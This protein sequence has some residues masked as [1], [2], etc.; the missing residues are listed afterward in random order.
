[1]G[2]LVALAIAQSLHEPGGG[3]AQV[4]GD[5][6]GKGVL[7]VRN[8]RGVGLVQ[9][10]GFGSGG[11]VDRSL[12][13]GQGPLR[14]TD[15]VEGFLGLHGHGQGVRVRHAHVFG[16]KADQSPG[17]VK[18]VLSGLQ[19][20]GQPVDRSVRV[21]V[22]K[23]FV[24]RRDEIVVFLA[25]LV[26]EKHT[27]LHRVSDQ[28]L[29]DPFPAGF[30]GWS[31]LNGNL[32]GVVG[33][34]GVS[35]GEVGDD[36]QVGVLDLDRVGPHPTLPVP[37]RPPKQL[38]HLL[39]RQRFQ[40]VDLATG[41]QGGI[42]LEGG[43]LGG[44]ADQDDGPGFDEGEKG[45]LLSLVETVNLVDE[46]QGPASGTPVPFRLLHHRADLLDSRKDRAEGDEVHPGALGDDA[47]Q[48]GLA[49][50]RRAPENQGTDAVLFQKQAHRLAGPD[51]VLLA[52]EALQPGGPHPVRQRGPL[53]R[54]ALPG[55]GKFGK[56]IHRAH[57]TT[58]APDLSIG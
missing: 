38:N 37:Q 5:R 40:L 39:G 44:G 45:I 29:A 16:G 8:G 47:G 13:Q 15:E 48:G 3:I 9:S 25:G 49:G 7:H 33:H 18:R 52:H 10:I 41:K 51:Q 24:Q 57:A 20:A 53:A 23:R 12:G 56:E 6:L 58:A 32:Q 14:K 17:D 2:V 43:I 55:R 50:T 36:A 54:R 26:V 46:Q 22:A 30:L 31:H 21:A 1:M 4:Q 42:H 28:L 35:I 19:H 11:Q 34:P 27:A